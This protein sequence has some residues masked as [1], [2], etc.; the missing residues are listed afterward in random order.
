[1]IDLA[2]VRAAAKRI[3]GRIRRT[4]V[5]AAAPDR[6]F[7]LEFTQHAGSFKTRGAVNKLAGLDAKLADAVIDGL[8]KLTAEMSTDP[9]HPVRIKVEEALAQLANDLHA[10]LLISI[11]IDGYKT[12]EADG[13]A[14]YH[15]GDGTSDGVTSTVAERLAG[16]V[17]REIVARTGL[18]NCQTHAKT[19]DLLRLTRMPA[20]RVELGYLTAPLDRTRLVDPLFRE[21]SIEAIVAAVQRMYF[22]VENDVP[23]GSIDVRKLR[24][25]VAAGEPIKA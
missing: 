9:A 1:M 15:Y 14:T 21:Q 3:D 22:P 6:W 13:V 7:K 2:D 17:Q 20:V 23:T 19:W 18:R 24:M 11:H 8:R 16:L 25:A 4:P 5:L 10:D 12:P